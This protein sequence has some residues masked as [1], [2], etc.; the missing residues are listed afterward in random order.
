V[1]EASDDFNSKM[2]LQWQ[3]N[4]NLKDG[5]YSFE[6]EGH[7]RLFAVDGCTPQGKQNILWNTPNILTQKFPA[8][9]FTVTTKMEFNPAKMG[10]NAGFIVQGEEYTALSLVKGQTDTFLTLTQGK[11][12]GNTEAEVVVFA[13]EAQSNTVYFQLKVELGT[14]TTANPY[15]AICQLSYSYDGATFTPVGKP[16]AA[17]PNKWVGAK[18]GMFCCA[19]NTT[20]KQGYAD[21]DWVI[22]E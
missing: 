11:F 12:R 6:H 14:P 10:E 13:A 18:F 8:E 19:K 7:L 4:A 17:T 15:P 1:L 2:G 22:V 3:W 16:F 21:F 9:A 5:W 20:A